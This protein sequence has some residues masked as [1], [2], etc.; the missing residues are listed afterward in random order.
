M[1]SHEERK[2][3]AYH[4]DTAAMTFHEQ[5]TQAACHQ[6][7]AATTMRMHEPQAVLHHKSS[8]MHSIIKAETGSLVPLI[9]GALACMLMLAAV[10]IDIGY[11]RERSIALANISESVALAG[12][13][14]V[15]T[16]ALVAQTP[17]NAVVRLPL[18]ARAAR[19]RSLQELR[20]SAHD[21]PG[22]TLV[23]L[24]IRD[25]AVR[26]RVCGSIVLPLTWNG[27]SQHSRRL[28]AAAAAAMAVSSRQ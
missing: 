10:V 9:V 18:L 28:C 19:T 20:S 17:G 22:L 8:V 4:Q 25:D 6:D 15:D 14:G 1:T 7:T 24:R 12:A 5:R 16:Q 21:W 23:S 13:V 2:Q 11:A 27:R 26:V 3:A